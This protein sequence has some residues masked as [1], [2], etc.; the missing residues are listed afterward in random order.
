MNRNKE[1][2]THTPSKRTQ[3][4]SS[5]LHYLKKGVKGILIF[6]S[7]EVLNKTVLRVL[8]KM[9]TRK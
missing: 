9:K 6:A 5:V 7:V 3:L 8:K 4:K 2:Q 1:G